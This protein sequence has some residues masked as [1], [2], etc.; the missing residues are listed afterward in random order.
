MT[1][2]E[3]VQ[4]YSLKAV[5]FIVDGATTRNQ[6]LQNKSLSCGK[7]GVSGAATAE[8]FVRMGQSPFKTAITL[9]PGNSARFAAIASNCVMLKREKSS[10]KK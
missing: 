2:R 9:P 6:S 7:T 10:E 4:P 1:V 5:P 8:L 3:Y